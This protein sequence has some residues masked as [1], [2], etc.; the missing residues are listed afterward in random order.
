MNTIRIG[1]LGTGHLGKIHL[2][3]LKQ[4]PAF[5]LVGFFDLNAE[6]RE[7]VSAEFDVPAFDNLD[8]LISQVDAMDIVTPTTTHFELASRVM[9]AG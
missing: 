1:L 2:K 7:K 6:T 9:Q 5:E 3:L 8:A 4:I